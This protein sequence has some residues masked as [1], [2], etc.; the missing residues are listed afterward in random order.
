MV[1]QGQPAGRRGQAGLVDELG[2][3]QGQ[4][5][6]RRLGKPGEQGLGHAQFEDRVAEKFQSFVVGQGFAAFVG[7]GT[8][9]QG[10]DEQVAVAEAMAQGLFQGDQGIGHRLSGMA[11]SASRSTW[12]GCS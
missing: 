7:P 4:L 2:A 10:R 8:V 3:K 1:L 12:S 11:L 6:F 9:G 5:A